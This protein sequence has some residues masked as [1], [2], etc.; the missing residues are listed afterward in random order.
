[1]EVFVGRLRVPSFRTTN[2]P[3]R[4]HQVPL[5][6]LKKKN[7]QGEKGAHLQPRLPRLNRTTLWERF[8]P[9][10]LRLG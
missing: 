3:I 7:A 6:T 1:M 4:P 2:I 9:N 5:S 10:G 8:P